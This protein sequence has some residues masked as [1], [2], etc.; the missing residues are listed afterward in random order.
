MQEVPVIKVEV[1]SAHKPKAMPPPV[2]IE[3][4]PGCQYP[5]KFKRTNP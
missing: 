5:P 2:S 4:N 1:V 3:T